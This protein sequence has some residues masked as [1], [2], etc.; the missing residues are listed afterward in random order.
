MN[1]ILFFEQLVDKWNAEQKCNSCW[2]FGAPL[3]E[4]NMNNQQAEDYEV[5]CNHLYITEY[6][7]SSGYTKNERTQMV[8]RTWCDHIFTLYVV[9]QS[10]LGINTYN[11]QT[12]HSIDESLWKTILEPLQNCLG[13]GNELE[14][15]EMGYE[16]EI[17]KWNMKVVRLQGDSNHTGWRILG[18]F[19]QY[20]L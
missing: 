20:T 15:C 1:V 11:E 19:R 13:C 9:K 8:N 4:K 10:D 3:S 18:I 2:T 5:C 14:L 7:T 6:E 12:E 17:F 16:F